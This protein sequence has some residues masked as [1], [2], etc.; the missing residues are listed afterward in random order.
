MV[1]PNNKESQTSLPINLIV[2]LVIVVIMFALGWVSYNAIVGD[3]SNQQAASNITSS[4]SGGNTMFNMG[5]TVIVVFAITT[6]VGLTYYCI[7]SRTRYRKVSKLMVFLTT[8]TYYFGWGLLSFVVIVIPG[9]LLYLTV[10]YAGE[11]GGTGALIDVSKWV[12]VAI[13]AYFALAGIGFVVKKKIVDNWRER[14]KEKE[15]ENIAEGLNK[16]M[17]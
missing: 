5:A 12:V 13:V 9:Y 16:V 1:E 4:I 3:M 14:R 2:T 6:L 7:S 8:T 15:E 17:S 11:A 10:Q